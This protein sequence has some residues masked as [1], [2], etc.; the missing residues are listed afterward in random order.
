MS[1]HLT[2]LEVC[3]RLIGP[4]ERIGTICRID[5][6]APYHW[7]R[8]SVGR[9]A[10]DVPSATHMR[11]LLDYAEAN[12]IPLTAAHLVRGAS[13]AEIDALLQAARGQAA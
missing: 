12:S 7:R 9:L 5:P 10:G 11:A 3:E 13:V 2:P 6:K 8:Q 1:E 4:L